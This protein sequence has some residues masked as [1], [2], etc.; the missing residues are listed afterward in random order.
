MKNKIFVLINKLKKYIKV[1]EYKQLVENFF[2][3]SVLNAVYFVFPLIALPYLLR[4]VGPEKYGI[5]VWWTTLM[6]YVILFSNYG[7]N[8]SATKQISINRDNKLTVSTIFFS[9]L[10]IRFFVS[11]L[12]LSLFILLIL[13]LPKFT[14]SFTIYLFSIGIAIGDIFIPIWLFQ[15]LEKMKYITIVNVCSKGIFTILVFFVI[16]NESDYLYIPLLTSIGTL[17]AGAVS[18]YLAFRTIKIVWVLPKKKDLIFQ[19]KDGWHIF[20]STIGMN[21]YRNANI[22]ILGLLTNNM[23]VGI[24]ASAEKLVKALQTLIE[25]V[26]VSLYPYFSKRFKST[27]SLKNNINTLLKLGKY[28]FIV[29]LLLSLFVFV[30]AKY[31]VIIA[32]G[33]KYL[34]SI[35]DVR[36]LSFVILFGGLNYFYGIIGLINLG[37]KKQFLSFV[38]IGGVISLLLCI[39]FSPYYFDVAA[40]ISM[41]AGEFVLSILLIRF[42]IKIKRPLNNMK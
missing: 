18:I 32:F 31:I 23:T 22:F 4:V 37:F 17:L 7:F 13:F 29:L 26:S 25:P 21:F 30:F 20:A 10:I 12:I 41:L 1:K 40:S 42:I 19:I 9:V 5:A 28:Y 6:Q 16:K 33:E 3:L 35:I 36:I 14:N 8:F 39:G 2:S 27:G 15:G 24:Y 34:G 11:L 38:L